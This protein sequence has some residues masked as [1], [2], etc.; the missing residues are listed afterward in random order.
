M[1]TA[2]F[3]MQVTKK[4]CNTVRTEGNGFVLWQTVSSFEFGNLI[5]DPSP[6][7]VHF[8]NGVNCR[9]IK[10]KSDASIEDSIGLF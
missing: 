2:C 6:R 7:Y 1:K 10:I 4:Y 5:N 9:Y 8:H 3:L